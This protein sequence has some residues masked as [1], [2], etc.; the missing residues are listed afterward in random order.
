MSNAGTWCLVST[1][2][3]AKQAKAWKT[4][5]VI[6]PSNLLVAISTTCQYEKL[7]FVVVVANTSVF[8]LRSRMELKAMEE[9]SFRVERGIEATE[10]SECSSC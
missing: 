1:R 4:C 6:L 5:F 9:S 3:H 2:H 8:F 10:R 7:F